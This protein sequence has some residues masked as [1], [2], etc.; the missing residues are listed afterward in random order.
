VCKGNVLEVPPR[1]QERKEVGREARKK[2]RKEHGE[3]QLA[4]AFFES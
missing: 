4:V 3:T 2:E 1:E